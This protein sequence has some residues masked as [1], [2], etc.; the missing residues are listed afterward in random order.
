MKTLKCLLNSCILK[1]LKD[2]E[3]YF[4]KKFSNNCCQYLRKLRRRKS[5]LSEYK[6]RPLMI[7]VDKAS[8][9][10]FKNTRNLINQTGAFLEIIIVR[11]EMKWFF[12]IIFR[13]DFIKQTA[14]HISSFHL[15]IRSERFRCYVAGAFPSQRSNK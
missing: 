10:R 8:P 7:P 3:Y 1:K 9:Q 2:V 11:Q 14:K 6:F 4:I 5:L 15:V 13:D 12:T